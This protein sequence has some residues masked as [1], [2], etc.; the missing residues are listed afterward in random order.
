MRCGR[1]FHRARVI[2]ENGFHALGGQPP[3]RDEPVGRQA[4]VERAFCNAVAIGNVSA[5]DR[6]ESHKIKMRVLQIERIER[7]FDEI[8]AT[9]QRILALK[10]FQAAPHAAVV[11]FREDGGHVR[12]QIRLARPDCCE[13]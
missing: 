13:R 3:F 11:E 12:M 9:L 4:G 6:A 5:R 1:F 7:P 8:D 2:R 10:K